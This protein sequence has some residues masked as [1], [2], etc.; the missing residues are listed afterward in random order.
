MEDKL[1]LA[2]KVINLEL[3]NIEKNLMNID[4]I[5]ESISTINLVSEDLEN[6]FIYE[7]ESCETR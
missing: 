7:R 5:I 3:D 6:I 4:S 1:T 2:R